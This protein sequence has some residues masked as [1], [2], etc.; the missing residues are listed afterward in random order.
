MLEKFIDF[1]RPRPIETDI[2][3]DSKIDFP[4]EITF[5]LKEYSGDTFIDGFFSLVDPIEYEGILK[6]IYVPF[7][8]PSNC[9]AK[10][11]FG[12]LYLWENNSIKLINIRHGISEIIGRNPSVFFN[13]KMTDKGFLAKRLGIDSFYNAKERLGALAYDECYGYVPILAAGGA[14]KIENMQKVKLKEHIAII[15]QLAGKI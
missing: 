14:E 1:S 13:L 3:F 6:D 2:V 12:S 11:A 15:S 4:D 9:F 10:D 8:K 5:L 7:K